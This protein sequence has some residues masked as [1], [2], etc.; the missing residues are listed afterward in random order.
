MRVRGCF[1]R[2]KG[3]REQKSLGKTFT[4]ESSGVGVFVCCTMFLF[5]TGHRP[6]TKCPKAHTHCRW[7]CFVA[8]VDTTLSCSGAI[9]L[10]KALRI[11]FPYSVVKFS[12]GK[13]VNNVQLWHR[14]PSTRC[15]LPPSRSQRNLWFD[16]AFPRVIAWHWL[17]PFALAQNGTRWR[18]DRL[19]A[20]L[21]RRP[22]GYIGARTDITQQSGQTPDKEVDISHITVYV[23][24]YTDTDATGMLSP[25]NVRLCGA[26]KVGL[27]PA[28]SLTRYL[29]HCA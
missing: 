25:N 3:V 11:S 28:D 12:S 13:N 20:Q 5:R 29:L 17:K 14:H 27:Y 16:S 15:D 4:E 26:N 22:R 21:W 19:S 23:S 8:R 7:T 6:E 18:T 1:S 9:G 2:P 24:G 10:R